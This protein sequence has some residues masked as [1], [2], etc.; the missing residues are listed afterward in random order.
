VHPAEQLWSEHAPSAGYPE[1]VIPV[2]QPIPGT[3]F[4][5]GGYGLWNPT[6]GRPLPAFPSGGIM[7]LGHD[8]HSESGYRNSLA[9]GAEPL[10][11]PT[12]RNLIGLLREAGLAPTDCFFTNAF[13][14]LRAGGVTTGR[15]PGASDPEFVG[16]C[17]RFLMRQ[18]ET[19]QP[20]LVLTLGVYAPHVLASLSPELVS[21]AGGSGLKHLD[22][23]GP[24]RTAVTFSDV[25]G[26]RTITV[27]LTHPS[28]RSTNARHRRYRDRSGAA[29]ELLMI[30][31]ALAQRR[32]ATS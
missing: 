6:G 11:Q 12:W 29:A 31:D 22:A 27:A 8:F 21:W 2:P 7:V 1:G 26:L 19:Q 5:P 17:R 13:M 28:L 32:A 3:A 16:H 20:S 25:P 18:L 23:A 4:F 9:R 10:T 15:F 24:V 14:G 30:R